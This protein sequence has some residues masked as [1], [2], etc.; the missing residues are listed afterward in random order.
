MSKSQ[1]KFPFL[2]KELLKKSIKLKKKKEKIIKLYTRDSLVPVNFIATV[3]EI[4]KGM[5]FKSYKFGKDQI[6]LRLG[7]FTVTRRRPR[8]LAKGKQPIKIRNSGVKKKS[9]FF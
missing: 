4:H 2:S 7:E 1:Y 5:G 8:L 3:L 6:G 9:M